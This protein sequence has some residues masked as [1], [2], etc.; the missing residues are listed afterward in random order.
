MV[1]ISTK[2]LEVLPDPQSCLD[3]LV[4]DFVSGDSFNEAVKDLYLRSI[5]RLKKSV[6]LQHFEETYK[7]IVNAFT[8]R[9]EIDVY[10]D[11]TLEYQELRKKMLFLY[12]E[13]Q[14][15]KSR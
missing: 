6:H 13:S 4:K 12:E 5:S 3:T 2:D 14:A 7:L 9:N 15:R 10:A 1:R 8:L 11:E